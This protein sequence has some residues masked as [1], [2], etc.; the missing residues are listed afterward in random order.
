LDKIVEALDSARAYTAVEDALVVDD[1]S[2]VKWDAETDFAIVGFGGAGSAAAV[3][4]AENGLKVIAVDRYEGGGAT[5]INGG[6]VYAG[7]GTTTQKAAGFHDTPDEMFDYLTRE[8]AGVVSDETL[9]R[10][11]NESPAMIDWLEAHGVRFNPKAYT[12]KTSYPTYEYYLYHSDNSLLAKNRGALAP[13]PRG[14]KC[15]TEGETKGPSGT[16]FGRGFYDPLR[17]AAEKAGVKV[18]RQTEARQL[19]LDRSGAVLGL[20][21]IT[22]PPDHPMH[23]DLVEAQRGMM[24]WSL[25]LPPAMPGA[26]ITMWMA[27]R[28]VKKAARIEAIAAKPYFIRARRGVCLAGGGFIFNTEMV[29]SM[30]PNFVNVMPLGTPGDDGS[31]ILLGRSAAGALNR[32]EHIS[33]WRFIN[34]PAALGKGM[35][36]NARGQRYV[37]EASYGSSIGMAMMN[38]TNK[39]VAWLILDEETW[40]KA[41]H[42]M[43]HEKLYD[44]QR[45]PFR[46]TMW[47]KSKKAPTLEAL[48]EKLGLDKATFAAT[49]AQYR[50]AAAGQ[51]KEPF[52]KA[53]A[54]MAAMTTGPFYALDVGDKSAFCPLP[55]ISL[56]GLRVDERTGE[57][58]RESGKPVPGLYAAGRSAIGI[59]SNIY[60]SGLSVADCIFSGRRAAQH[61]AR[62]TNDR[63]AA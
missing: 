26:Q 63:Q 30:A 22:V 61:V 47:F 32:M 42:Q 58:L 28:Y 51:A 29:R 12:K 36:V 25:M 10:F 14:H 60:V 48:G 56:G 5:A 9:R 53:P 59:C 45:D 34:P 43:A 49:A 44:F 46:L 4:A 37:D 2:A 31:S 20:K 8:T 38:D 15:E 35:I 54:D 39:G 24:K 17:K 21:V 6:V 7:G 62:K 1:E 11:C 50:A 3:E 16:G 52:D 27:S 57:V 23:K 33:S 19:I 55:S 41:K 18:M 40:Q 13:V